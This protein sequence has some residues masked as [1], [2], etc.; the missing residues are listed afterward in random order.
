LQLLAWR[1]GSK[2]LGAML[3]KD[4]FLYSSTDLSVLTFKVLRENK[5]L[6]AF[7]PKVSFYF[8]KKKCFGS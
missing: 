6:E 5:N 1:G 2:F 7:L 8:F 4:K 3:F